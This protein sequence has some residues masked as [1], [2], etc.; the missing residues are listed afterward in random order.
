MA[1]ASLSCGGNALAF[2]TT[3]GRPVLY[4]TLC[5][6]RI[7]PTVMC[8]GTHAH[9]RFTRLF[10][11]SCYWALLDEEGELYFAAHWFN[12]ETMHVPRAIFGGSKVC[13]VAFGIEHVLLV[14]TDN[15]LFAGGYKKSCALGPGHQVDG[16]EFVDML[17][18][19]KS[20]HMRR[21]LK[22][23]E[24]REIA[25]AGRILGVVCAQ[26]SSGFWTKDGVWL[27]GVE[28][29]A[30]LAQDK[31]KQYARVVGRQ[32]QASRTWLDGWPDV[33]E[34]TRVAHLHLQ[35]ACKHVALGRGHAGVVDSTG[36]VYMWGRNDQGQCVTQNASHR[37][38]PC[39]VHRD[40]FDGDAIDTIKVSDEHTTFLTVTGHVWTAGRICGRHEGKL[41]R[42]P[43]VVF[44]NKLVREI[45]ASRGYVAAINDSGAVFTWGMQL[46]NTDGVLQHAVVPIGALGVCRQA[47]MPKQ[48]N[49]CWFGSELVGHW[50]R[51]LAFV[52]AAHERL[53]A[54]SAAAV[55][56]PEMLRYILQ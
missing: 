20:Q 18:H 51:R 17:N 23:L 3:S 9:I 47:A 33:H 10:N 19:M 36:S 12:G 54:E 49:S 45:D 8:R 11:A 42:L 38:W 50:F 5:N 7:T 43:A 25:A 29:S 30:L 16:G 46:G 41:M 40:A 34:P 56:H 24:H 55:L 15:N 1:N 14:T 28:A 27:W 31:H 32:I 44:G 52:M 53:G 37:F 39:Q 2:L 26:C 21:V 4:G 6:F 13:G 35:Q 22:K 48:I